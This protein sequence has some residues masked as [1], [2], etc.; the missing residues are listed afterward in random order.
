MTAQATELLIYEGE[1]LAL[2]SE[3][4]ELYLEMNPPPV[5][6]MSP[7]TGLWRGYIGTWTIE[8]NRLYLKSIEATIQNDKDWGFKEVGL[9]VVFPAYPDG[10]FA[11]WFSGE[12]RCTKG[13]L[14]KYVHGGFGSVYEMD[15][16]FKVKKGVVVD[17]REVVNGVGSKGE[18]LTAFDDDDS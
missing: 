8:D 16:F 2:C 3:P 17:R 11:H 4:L 7:H 1:E 10:V 12:L 18:Q 6:F 9:D 13:A 14:L 5:K 15:L